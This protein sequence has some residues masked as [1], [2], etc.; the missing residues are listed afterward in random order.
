MFE[1]S[2][3]LTVDEFK[4]KL[5]FIVISDGDEKFLIKK[6]VTPIGARIYSSDG[7]ND[8]VVFWEEIYKKTKASIDRIESDSAKIEESQN[9]REI[10]R[11]I[12]QDLPPFL[13]H[14]CDARGLSFDE[15]Y[16]EN[17]VVLRNSIG[18]I[19]NEDMNDD[20]NSDLF[21]EYFSDIKKGKFDYRGNFH[22]EVVEFLTANSNDFNDLT[23]NALDDFVKRCRE[24]DRQDI[25]DS[26]TVKL[27]DERFHL[28]IKLLTA[29][30]ISM[31]KYGFNVAACSLF[32]RA[33]S[34]VSKL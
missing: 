17:F 2:E 25:I 16:S 31:S 21:I 12:D 15:A 10:R 27:S 4:K 28:S 14:I 6:S 32:N 7:R 5:L 3:L 30:A 8:Y 26:L 34:E 18:L 22:N 9:L 19:E 24:N 20:V 13:K 33:S 1:V 29:F 11:I 23:N